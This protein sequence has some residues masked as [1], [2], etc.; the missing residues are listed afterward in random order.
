MKRYFFHCVASTRFREG[1]SWLLDIAEEIL[2][3]DGLLVP[4]D[5]VDELQAMLDDIAREYNCTSKFRMPWI[6]I[7]DVGGDNLFV[8]R[9]DHVR[10]TFDGRGAI[11][12]IT[13]NK[14]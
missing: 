11:Q 12:P 3:N 2:D 8:L 6:Y 14:H 4:E 9:L 5:K 10:G 1:K 13:N 7:K